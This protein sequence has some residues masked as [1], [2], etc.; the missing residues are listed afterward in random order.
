MLPTIEKECSQFLEQS[1]GYPLLKNLPSNTDGFR[2]VKVRKRNQTGMIYNLFDSTFK[3]DYSQILQRC[4]FA[5]GEQGLELPSEDTEPFYIFPIDGYKFMY[6][7]NVIS[8]T[9]NYKNVLDLLLE[10]IG[11]TAIETL[12]DVL[13]YQY[14]HD[15]LYEALTEQS[16]IIIYNIPYFYAIRKTLVDNYYEFLIS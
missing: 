13:K 12:Q 9:D 1:F 4:V 8:T 7:E 14:K 15:K 3:E 6:A 5:Y 11:D 2:K 10:T 16:E